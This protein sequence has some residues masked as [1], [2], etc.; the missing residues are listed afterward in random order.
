MMKSIFEGDPEG[1]VRA[2]EEAARRRQQAGVV[3]ENE[4]MPPSQRQPAPISRQGGSGYTGEETATRNAMLPALQGLSL[5][6]SDEALASVMAAYAQLA[7][8]IAGGLPADDP[9]TYGETYRGMRDTM[10]E[11]TEEYAEANPKTA[12]AAELAGGLATGGAGLWKT[13][14]SALA[15]GIKARGLRPDMDT[16]KRVGQN[17]GEILSLL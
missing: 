12:M 14:G 15:K 7:P 8:E 1:E 11:S 6:W 17:V 5:N 4:P 13:G 16:A 2:L 10:R 9:R 3:A